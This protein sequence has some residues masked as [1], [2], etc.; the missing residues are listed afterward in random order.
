[1]EVLGPHPSP[2]KDFAS[3]FLRRANFRQGFERSSHMVDSRMLDITVAPAPDKDF[4]TGFSPSSS[5]RQG[6]DRS[7]HTVDSQLLE[8]AEEGGC[9]VHVAV[10]K[11]V[12]K[13]IA[14][15]EWTFRT[16]GSKE[17]C[18]L[19]VHR[20]SPLIP[21]LLGKL[22]ASQANPEMVAAFRN[23]EKK[24]TRKLLRN[25]LI[26]CSKSKVKARVI[27]TE[28]DE[29]Q[30]G[31]V[32]LVNKH[33]IKTLVIGAI[34]DFVKGKK[35]SC[36]ASH[37]ARQVPYYCEIRFVNKG[38]LVWTRQASE[39]TSFV[40]ICQPAPAYAQNLRFQSLH[41]DKNKAETSSLCIESSRDAFCCQD[42]STS[43]SSSSGSDY[44]SAAEP[45]VS[46][47]CS[48]NAE[49]KSLSSLL[50]ELEIKA[51]ESK[52]EAF[53][54]LSKH[55]KLKTNVM[56][57]VN[58][59]KALEISYS[60]EVK[61]QEEAQDAM[62]ATIQEQ[63][64]LVEETEKITYELHKTMR[65]I[66]LLDSR[67]REANRRREEVAGELELIQASIATL[68]K[69][70]QKLQRQ[71]N[72]ATRWL[73][74]WKSHGQYGDA[75]P[76]KTFWLT[77]DTSELAE[78]SL[79]DLHAA[80][81]NFSESFRIG[82]GGY[83]TV[84]KGEM[85][86][87]TVAIKKLHPYAMQGQ[88]EFHKEVQVLGKLQHPHVVGLIGVCPEAWSLVYE[89]LPGGNLQTRLLHYSGIGPLN[90]KNRA[91]IVANIASGL[92]FLH[93]S[94]PEKLVHGNLKLE[95]V[96]IDSENSCRIS[97][98]GIRM[99]ITN[100]TIRCP[101]FRHCAE[102]NGAFAYQDPEFLR[103][104]T[105]T[106][107]SDIYSFGLI[108]LQLLTGR[109]TAGLVSEV[110]WAVSSGKVASILDLSAGEWSSYV[111]R[112][113][114][115]L[116]LQCCELNSRDRPELSPTLVRELERLPVLEE[117]EVP[118]FFLCPILRE[119]M[120]DPQVAADGF[121]YEGE[122]L[123]GWMENGHETSPMTNLKLSHLN[124][125]P[126]HALQI[127]IQDWLCKC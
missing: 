28:A 120:H 37:A 50:A 66:A 8:I 32:D 98:Y 57:A 75:E 48:T 87:R 93:S 41:I 15:L 35:S 118:L 46:S 16:F 101:S 11:S 116:G 38:K 90:W 23:E 43:T 20:P 108:I 122:A 27:T 49:E 74:R 56:E 13:T 91:R 85:L 52:D 125:T 89:Y 9:A 12:K 124:L 60:E 123:R 39:S 18:I 47:V 94:K 92:L 111:A 105:L 126:N 119:I 55:K 53:L 107:K 73:H 19:H 82:Q 110:R 80:T 88:T 117:Q 51:E 106:L 4:I 40:P 58:K 61:L 112:R 1:M 95:N 30:K 97:D 22:P 121:T 33:G 99:L 42:V 7:N 21:T 109:T 84:Y 25:Y 115:H 104:G 26:I 96:L 44:T 127:A 59:V 78:F 14:L 34:P 36:K 62:R 31:I 71:K 10:G 102:S 114:V 24:D 83:G 65:N 54:E 100:K 63:E 103:T 45:R 3:G 72:E 17:I 29:V 77:G 68:R 5:F 2:D 70:K 64:D 113:L 86:D 67:V 6:F 81:C 69:E 76:D 79:S